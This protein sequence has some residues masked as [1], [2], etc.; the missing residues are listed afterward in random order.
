ML[1]L[2]MSLRAGETAIPLMNTVG[3]HVPIKQIRELSLY[4]K[5]S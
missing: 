3:I 5:V 2:L 1:Y 4:R